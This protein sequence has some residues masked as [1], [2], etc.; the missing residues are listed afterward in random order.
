MRE[1]ETKGLLV[2]L[3]HEFLERLS[4]IKLEVGRGSANERQEEGCPMWVIN[5][6]EW[7]A[8]R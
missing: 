1:A 3:G 6:S 7:R 5:A 4:A 8:G 2:R